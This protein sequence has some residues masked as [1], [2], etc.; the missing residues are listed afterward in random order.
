ML[1]ACGACS[2]CTGRI[3]DEDHRSRR[4]GAEYSLAPPLAPSAEGSFWSDVGHERRSANSLPAPALALET[5]SLLFKPPDRSVARPPRVHMIICAL[6]YEDTRFPSSCSQ[7]GRNMMELARRCNARVE[8]LY[9]NEA[10]VANVGKIIR[11][12]GSRCAAGDVLVFFYAGHGARV[13]GE[14]FGDVDSREEAFCF[15]DQKGQTSSACWLS[16]ADLAALIKSHVHPEAELIFL[17]D[18]GCSGAVVDINK[19]V[20]SG[21]RVVSISG[22]QERQPVGDMGAGGKFTHA[23]LLAMENLCSRNRPKCTIG[24]VY[25]QILAVDDAVFHSAQDI[26]IQ[27]RPSDS[28]RWPLMPFGTFTAPL[29]KTF[30]QQESEVVS[31]SPPPPASSPTSPRSGVG[32]AVTGPPTVHMVICALDYANTKCPLTCTLDGENIAELASL[33]NAKINTLVNEDATVGKVSDLVHQVG[34]RCG[35]GDYFIFYYAGHGASLPDQDGDEEDGKDEAFCFVDCN[36]RTSPD[37]WL[38]DD[39]FAKL[40]TSSVH[41]E[42]KIII[43][44]DCCHSG[45]VAD[46]NKTVWSGYQVVSIAGCKD[47]QT[48]GD[49]GKGGIFTHSFLLAVDE[50]CRQKRTAYSLGELYRETCKI[51][52]TVFRSVQ[53]ISIQAVPDDSLPW[54]LVPPTQYVAPLKRD[55]GPPER[56][57]TLL[58]SSVGGQGNSVADKRALR[59][60]DVVAT[61]GGCCFCRRERHARAP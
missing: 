15:V 39:D 22:C 11:E 29:S 10:T 38:R 28:M 4:P 5:G 21:R 40:V 51:D 52:D 7:S 34:S 33:C 37:C 1:S 8:S 24:E 6:D 23:L 36:G 16:D 14:A 44:A 27:A 18:C 35:A 2:A 42:T 17:A 12:V 13:P 57:P 46:L 3:C 32:A 50:L 19:S 47:E 59:S 49:T 58:H 55:A 53:D 41:P 56:L 43:L 31:A 61:K 60:P 26:T 9:N 25:A 20:W 54:P 45:T 48:S 30:E